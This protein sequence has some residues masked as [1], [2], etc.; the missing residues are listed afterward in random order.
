MKRPSWF[1]LTL[2]AWKS[3]LSF[4]NIAIQSSFWL[5]FVYNF[6]PFTFNPFMPLYLKCV[7]CKLHVTGFCL[8]LFV[9]NLYVLIQ[10]FSPFTFDVIRDICVLIHHH[11]YFPYVLPIPSFFFFF[12]FLCLSV[13]TFCFFLLIYSSTKTIETTLYIP[14]LLKSNKNEYLYHFLDIIW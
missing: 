8:L 4:F 7:S 10:V 9:Y 1:L 5:I 6:P 13:T 3:T 11:I 12:F 14:N 2:L